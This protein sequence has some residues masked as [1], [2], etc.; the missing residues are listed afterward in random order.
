MVSHKIIIDLPIW[1]RLPAGFRSLEKLT[2]EAMILPSP[3]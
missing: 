1:N 3:G 2:V